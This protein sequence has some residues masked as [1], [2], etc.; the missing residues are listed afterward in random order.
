MIFL[1]LVFSTSWTVFILF[2]W[3]R[4]D[5]LLF[6][7]ETFGL[8]SIL[9]IPKFKQLQEENIVDNFLLF[10][11]MQFQGH[12]FWR[13]PA[14]LVSCVYCFGFWASLLVVSFYEWE[15]LALNYLLA[16]L[17]FQKTKGNE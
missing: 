7:A 12:R 8:S 4:T 6:Y 10:L 17:V 5:F 15:L 2:L 9:R 13:F 11:W 1:S 16:I 14:K 3:F